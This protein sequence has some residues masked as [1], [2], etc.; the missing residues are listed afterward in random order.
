MFSA[1]V[2]ALSAEPATFHILLDNLLRKGILN[3]S[4]AASYLYSPEILNFIHIDSWIWSHAEVVVERSLDLVL[5]AYLFRKKLIDSK[6]TIL[7][8]SGGSNALE[9]QNQTAGTKKRRLGE[10]EEEEGDGNKDIDLDMND[11]LNVPSEETLIA[12]IQSSEETLAAAVSSCSKTYTLTIGSLL[13]A[14]SLRYHEVKATGSEED[15]LLHLD[16]NFMSNF[17]LLKKLLRLFHGTERELINHS[18]ND[19]QTTYATIDLKITS[20][21]QVLSSFQ[22]AQISSYEGL[23]RNNPECLQLPD[24]ISTHFQLMP[25]I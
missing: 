14:C 5:A 7:S 8:N 18:K 20:L 12:S 3:P 2:E 16:P 15:H 1:F 6:S 9:D 23:M 17:S 24:I 25:Y 4:N 11:Q 19:D 10:D 21:G 22:K 13:A